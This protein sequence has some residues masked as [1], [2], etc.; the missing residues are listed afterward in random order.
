LS[1]WYSVFKAESDP[2]TAGQYALLERLQAPGVR[3]AYSLHI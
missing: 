2:F 1:I 3:V